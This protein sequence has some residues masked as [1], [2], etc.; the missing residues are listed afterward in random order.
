MTET[1]ELDLRELELSP[2]EWKLAQQLADVLKVCQWSHFL[3]S[4]FCYLEHRQRPQS[5]NAAPT[6]QEFTA[7]LLYHLLIT[8]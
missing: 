2:E 5:L 7:H 4:N 1:R 3:N 8:I 6:A